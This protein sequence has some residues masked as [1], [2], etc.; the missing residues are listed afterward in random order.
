MAEARLAR[1]YIDQRDDFKGAMQQNTGGGGAGLVGG[2][3]RMIMMES[4]GCQ[5]ILLVSRCVTTKR[6]RTQHWGCLE[7]QLRVSRCVTTKRE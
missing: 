3:F 1:R 5:V 2:F 6:G 4:S 7:I